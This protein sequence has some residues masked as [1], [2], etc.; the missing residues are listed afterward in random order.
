MPY[1]IL[2]VLISFAGIYFAWRYLSLIYAM[3]KVREDIEHIRQDLTQNQILHMP[4]PDAHLGKL[5]SSF[6]LVLDGIQKERQSYEQKE[7]KFR[8][9]I[10]NVS[11]DLRTPLTVILGYLKVY[12]KTNAAGLAKDNELYETINI[13]EQKAEIMKKL[14]SQFY[15]FS[16]ITAKD[17]EIAMENVDISRFLREFLMGNY[18]VLGEKDLQVKIDI[19]E[20]P[21]RILGDETALERIFFNLI[22]NVGRYAETCFLAE[23]R[24]GQDSV[25]VLF[26]NDT[27]ILSEDDIPH[28]FDSFYMQDKPRTQGGTGLGLTIARAL[29]KEM[30]GTLEARL[31]SGK[32]EMDVEVR[33]RIICFILRLRRV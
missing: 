4:V 11:H 6:N 12:K 9:Q 25:S 24:E 16:R 1:I 17:Y 29:A 19:P 10:E 30:G 8:K 3:K 15:D 23:V 2:F 26:T 32:P 27:C 13:L 33:G 21:V 18:E 5:L 20:H 7:R 22:Q 28:L 31:Y 14:V